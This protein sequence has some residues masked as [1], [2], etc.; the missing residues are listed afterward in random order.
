MNLEETNDV[1]PI[2]GASWRI[3]ATT[4]QALGEHATRYGLVVVLLWIGAM[5]FTSYEAL[6]IQP[7]VANSPLMSW[8]YGVFSVQGFSSLLGVTEIVIGALIALRPL[9]AKLAAVGSAL[10]A[11]MFLTTLTFIFSTPGWEPSLGGFPA[12]SAGVGQ[13]ILKDVVLLGAALWLL[14]EALRHVGVMDAVAVDPQGRR[15]GTTTTVGARSDR[16]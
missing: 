10:A 12:L 9:S 13:F 2:A 8:V 16:R 11:G 1:A 4:V 5:K 3:G 14:G 6:G 15:S 7:L